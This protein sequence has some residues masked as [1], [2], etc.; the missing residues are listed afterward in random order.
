M[1]RGQPIPFPT[2]YDPDT[3]ILVRVPVALIPILGAYLDRWV[4]RS[5]WADGDFEKARQASYLLQER[6][7]TPV[8]TISLKE[9]PATP[10]NPPGGS[11]TLFCRDNG[12]KTEFCVV[13]DDGSVNVLDV[14][15]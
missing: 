4:S 5:A 2:N 13:Y 6:I 12:G 15:L 10:A 8:E 11:M 3:N 9:Q 7:V 14:Q 1:A